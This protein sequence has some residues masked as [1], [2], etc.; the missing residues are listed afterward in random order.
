MINFISIV[1]AQASNTPAG[2]SATK[3]LCGGRSEVGTAIGC[4][5]F[6]D[7][8]TLARTSAT[9]AIGVAGSI[10]LI[11]IAINSF[12]IMTS[13]G[14]P[15]SLQSAKDGLFSAIAGLLM[16]IFSGFILRFIGV[17]ILG[18]FQ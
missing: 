5:P 14:D 10:T 11:A 2:P 4:L 7:T 13:K 3:V 18:L 17:D 8:I 16:I 15:K 1:F 9:I 12:R 6:G